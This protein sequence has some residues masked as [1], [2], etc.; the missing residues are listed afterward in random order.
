[1]RTT[2]PDTIQTQYTTQWSTAT[3]GYII[4]LIDQSGSMKRKFSDNESRSQFAAK[5]VN[6]IIYKLFLHNTSGSAIKDRVRLSIIGY[7]GE[8][9]NS[10]S[11]LRTDYLSKYA[12][13]PLRLE[14]HIKAVINRNGTVSERVTER[15]IFVEPTAKGNSPIYYALD[16]AKQK[17]E[18]WIKNN[19]NYPAPIIINITDGVPFTGEMTKEKEIERTVKIAEQIKGLTTKDGSSLIYSVHIDKDTEEIKFPVSEAELDENSMAQFL[20]KICSPVPEAYQAA[21]QHFNFI[22]RPDSK[23]FIANASA[24]NLTMFIHFGSSAGFGLNK[25]EE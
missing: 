18:E 22:V 8:G 19:K 3:P 13:T 16:L 15:P 7:G 25:I 14:K 9:G 11:E 6:D 12:E 24:D 20:Y 10:L 23:G 17:I 21:A 4:F 1:M 5:A 2:S